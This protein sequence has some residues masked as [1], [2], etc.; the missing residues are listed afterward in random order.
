[1]SDP[2]VNINIYTA[3]AANTTT[4]Q[5]PGPGTYLRTIVLITNL[6]FY[7]CLERSVNGHSLFGFWEVYVVPMYLPRIS[8]FIQYLCTL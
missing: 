7:S 8:V 5:V 3:E 2:G 1:M 6:C 4:Y